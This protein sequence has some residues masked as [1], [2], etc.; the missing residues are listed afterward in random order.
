MAR[1]RSHTPKFHPKVSLLPRQPRLLSF[2][3][4]RGSLALPAPHPHPPVLAVW[5]PL[6]S[7]PRGNWRGPSIADVV[8]SL[9]AP[10]APGE[11]RLGLFPIS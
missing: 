1:A 7:P 10:S 9:A 6:S 8:M 4:G 11:K 5:Y 3:G 2:R